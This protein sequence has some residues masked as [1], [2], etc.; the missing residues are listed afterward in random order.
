MKEEELKKI[1]TEIEKLIVFEQG[2][3]IMADTFFG[4]YQGYAISL[5]YKKD[6]SSIWIGRFTK[7]YGEVEL[8]MSIYNCRVVVE[9]EQILFL[10][11][12]PISLGE[13]K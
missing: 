9:H 10:G 1:Q 6:H 11:D 7:Q 3:G 13:R 4:K 2:K 8:S 12:T 5:T